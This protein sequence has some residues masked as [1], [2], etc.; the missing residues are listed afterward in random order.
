[1][2]QQRSAALAEK[3]VDSAV[4]DLLVGQE[5]PAFHDAAPLQGFDDSCL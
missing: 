5:I 2:W 1:M 3:M 4:E